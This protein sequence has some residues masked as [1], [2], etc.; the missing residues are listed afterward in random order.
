M[1]VMKVYH[2]SIIIISF[3]YSKATQIAARTCHWSHKT[4]KVTD[5][6]RLSHAN[7]TVL[8]SGATERPKDKNLGVNKI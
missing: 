8:A 1:V 4:K 7:N 6:H 5:T 3:V 2:L